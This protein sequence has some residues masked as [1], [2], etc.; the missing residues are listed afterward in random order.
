MESALM[1]SSAALAEYGA[2]KMVIFGIHAL[3]LN[4]LRK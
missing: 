1:A 4:D 2:T 3:T